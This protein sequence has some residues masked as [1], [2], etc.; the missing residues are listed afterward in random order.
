M[1]KKK[2]IEI[3]DM[4]LVPE[5]FDGKHQVIPIIFGWRGHD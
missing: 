2:D 1:S 3:D 4:G 5:L